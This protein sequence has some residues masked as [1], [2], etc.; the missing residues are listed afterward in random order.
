[1]CPV[2]GL[3]DRESLAPRFP[4]LGKLRKGGAKPQ[5]GF[6]KDLDY[7]RFTSDES[8][9]VKAFVEAYGEKPNR[10]EVYLP[11]AQPDENFDTW[12]EEWSAGGLVHRCD[13]ETCTIHRKDDGTYSHKPVPCPYV[14]GKKERTDKNPGCKIVGRLA[15]IL[16]DLLRAGFVG[17][18]VLE[19]HS[20][21]DLRN[22]MATLLAVAEARPQGLQGIPFTLRRYKDKISTPASNGKR[23]RREKSLVALVPAP[24][25]VES[26][27][28]LAR[29]EAFAALPS[30]DTLP[31]TETNGAY[32]SAEGDEEHE[33]IESDVDKVADGKV[34]QCEKV[35]AGAAEEQPEPAIAESEPENG[36]GAAVQGISPSSLVP[37]FFENEQSAKGAVKKSKV[38]DFSKPPELVK[39]WSKAYRGFRDAGMNSDQAV[40]AADAEVS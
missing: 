27:M 26:R 25:W 40:Q 6:G 24:T 28:A 15:V 16:P 38:I 36:N 19:T 33:L 1:M 17:Y 23:A 21:H 22:I 10:L 3:T 20:N 29:A 4:R 37:A 2:K 7:F 14:N 12:M 5:S 9:V 32:E 11:Y 31:T 30:G 39:R 35:A 8:E 13:G 18:V 34:A